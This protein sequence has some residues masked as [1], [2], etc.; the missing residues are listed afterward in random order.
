MSDEKSKTPADSGS[1]ESTGAMAPKSK[2]EAMRDRLKKVSDKAGPPTDDWGTAPLP[3]GQ[4]FTK[5]EK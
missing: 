4:G 5:K 1:Q 2:R 3:E